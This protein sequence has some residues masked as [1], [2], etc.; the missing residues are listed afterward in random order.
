MSVD[1][2]LKKLFQSNVPGHWQAIETIATTGGV[3]DL[4]VCRNGREVWVETKQTHAWAV[5]F[6]PLQVSWIWSRVR[7]GGNVWVA[8]RRWKRQDEADEL[9]LVHGALVRDLASHGL[10]DRKST[11]LNSSHRALSRMPSSA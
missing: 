5:S 11:R 4:N 1:G 7:E 2:N 10:R 3:P 6:R 8:V 9:W